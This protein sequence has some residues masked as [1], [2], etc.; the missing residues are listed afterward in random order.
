MVKTIEGYLQEFVLGF[1]VL[2]ILA[3]VFYY[4][5]PWFFSSPDIIYVKAKVLQI[6]AGGLYTDPITGYA[7]FH[8]PFYHLFLAPWKAMGIGFNSILVGV[9]ILNVALLVLFTYKVIKVA[10]GKTAAFY[11][12]LMLPFIV[13]YM[14]C[15]NILLASAFYFSVPI[16]LAGL[17][18]YL[19]EDLIPRRAVGAAALWG[20][21]FLISPV[22]LFVVGFT[23]LYDLAIAKRLRYFLIMAATF[24]IV[25][26]PFFVQAAIIYSRGLW[27]AS[28]FAFWRGIPDGVW[29]RQFAIEFLSPGTEGKIGIPTAIH[30]VIIIC[31]VALMIRDRKIHR[32]IPIVLLAY[33]LTFYHYSG[34]YAIRIHLFLSLFLVAGMIRGLEKRTINGWIWKAAVM[35]LCAAALLYHNYNANLTFAHETALFGSVKQAGEGLWQ[36]MGRHLKEGEYVFCAKPIYREYVMPVFLV[37]TLGA[38]RSMEYFQLNPRI[39][40]ELENDY[41]TAMNSNDPETIERI[42]SKY[43]ITSAIISG[44]DAATP[45]FSTLLRLWTPVYRD[46]YFV[47]L[48]KPVA[49]QR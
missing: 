42:A 9:T 19:K 46:S 45:L 7:T 10:F 28:A 18:L 32:Y 17:W 1:W 48:K 49:E 39:A 29:W 11:T 37:H 43:G 12:S 13:E 26:I 16:Y 38:Y 44:R 25:L 14:G 33:L 3:P 2:V 5:V 31:A 40:Q 41:Q 23:L 34:D 22:Y 27:G 24:L 21:A 15:R 35:V 6:L 4:R 47:I 30:L 8:P 36:N 20:L